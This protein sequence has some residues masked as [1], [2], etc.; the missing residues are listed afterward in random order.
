MSNFKLTDF[1]IQKNVLSKELCNSMIKDTTHEHRQQHQWYIN[2]EDKSMSYEDK[3]FDVLF[4]SSVITQQVFEQVVGNFAEYF[5][6]CDKL[7]QSIN[8]SKTVNNCCGIRLNRYSA[9]T[10]MRP[11]F[12]H[13]HSLFDGQ[14]KG[15]PVLSMIGI[16]NDEFEGGEL[17]FFEDYKIKTQV[18][19]LI[20]FPSCFLYPHRINEV[21]SG[22]RYSFVS[23]AW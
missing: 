17:V 2:S 1:I 3:E 6:V 7:T 15:I 16:L 22:T 11:H 14:Q 23:W 10:C 5:K 12:D 19:D 20:V 21:I 8:F 13:I 18:G 9:G 4:P